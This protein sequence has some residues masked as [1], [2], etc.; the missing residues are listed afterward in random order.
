MKDTKNKPLRKS[1]L[2]AISLCRGKILDLV[3]NLDLYK[4]FLFRVGVKYKCS[5]INHWY[6]IATK[7][8]MKGPSKSNANR[9]YMVINEAQILESL[10]IMNLGDM[11]I[12]RRATP[13]EKKFNYIK[14]KLVYIPKNIQEKT[15]QNIG[16][17]LSSWKQAAIL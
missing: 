4:M 15:W 13:G 14:T 17:S 7:Q 5:A 2:Y 1:C 10:N 9:L 6:S 8:I 12:R 16:T 11:Y 3:L